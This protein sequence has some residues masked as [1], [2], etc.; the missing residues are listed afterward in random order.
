MEYLTILLLA[1]GLSFDTFA[2]SLSCGVVQSRIRFFQAVKVAFVMALFQGGLPVAGYF[3][4]SAIGNHFEALDHWI[5]FIL[6]SA[7]GANM[8]REG[9]SGEKQESARDITK[10]PI[11]LT[12][13]IGTSIDAFVAGIGL[14]FIGTGIWFAALAIGAVTFIA[15]MI[16]IRLGKGVSDRFGS[17]VEI[18]GGVILVLIGLKVV[19]EH[20]LAA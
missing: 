17:R 15:S 7:I 16:A 14:G 11:L 10:L 4:G 9:A 13:G 12:L 18:V 8:I 20:I 5:A 6:L 2:V 19:L 3:I 1:A